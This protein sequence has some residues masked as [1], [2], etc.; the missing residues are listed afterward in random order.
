MYLSRLYFSHVFSTKGQI[1]IL[2]LF[3]LTSNRFS[4]E[5]GNLFGGFSLPPSSVIAERTTNAIR[6]LLLRLLTVHNPFLL[7]PV[8]LLIVDVLPLRL[9][10]TIKMQVFISLANILLESI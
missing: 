8:K 1:S 2:Y 3:L 5:S 7:H 10:P 6:G 9:S 4:K